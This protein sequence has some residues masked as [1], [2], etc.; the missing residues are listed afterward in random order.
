M[1]EVD[2]IIDGLARHAIAELRRI[3]LTED[4]K[5]FINAAGRA[6][7][8]KVFDYLCEHPGKEHL[9]PLIMAH[10]LAY[11]IGGSRVWNEGFERYDA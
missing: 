5:A 1:S 6:M 3:E 7:A 9:R 10:A 2:A 4:E 11:N 8:E